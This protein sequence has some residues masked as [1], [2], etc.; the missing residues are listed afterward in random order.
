MNRSGVVSSLGGRDMWDELPFSDEGDDPKPSDHFQAGPSRQQE[1]LATVKGPKREIKWI[2]I[3]SNYNY[4]ISKE[5]DVVERKCREGIPPEVRPEAWF[6][7]SGGHALMES[8]PKLLSLLMDQKASP[9]ITNQIKNDLDRLFPHHVLFSD[10]GPDQ[11]QLLLILQAYSVFNPKV[12]Y[13]QAQGPLAGFI[14]MHMKSTHLTFYC[15]TAICEDF[16]SDYYNPGLQRL[17]QDGKFLYYLLKKFSPVSYKHLTDQGIDPMFFILD[18]F[19]CAYTRTLPPESLVR[20]W[21]MFLC[22]GFSVILKVALA[23]IKGCF[24]DSSIRNRCSLMF[25]SLQ[26]LQRLPNHVVDKETLMSEVQK[27]GFATEFYHYAVVRQT[28]K[29]KF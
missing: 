2:D 11:T 7:L 24:E 18:W 26:I 3:L 20:V 9:R 4:Y 13:C 14:L 25:E 22:E 6:W 5:Y 15:F 8:A 28:F 23:L 21:D 17:Q 29:N 1:I 16:L 12:G 19:M 10:N 27:I